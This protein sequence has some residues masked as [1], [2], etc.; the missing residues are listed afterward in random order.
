MK[1][2][3]D[4]TE[5]KNIKKT[6]NMEQIARIQEKLQE[7]I[8]ILLDK[9]KYLQISPDPSITGKQ[10]FSHTCYQLFQQL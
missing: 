10:H 2:E 4:S 5:R 1:G 7:Q 3:C 8:T 6:Q 9:K